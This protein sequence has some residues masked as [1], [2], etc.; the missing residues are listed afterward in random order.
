VGGLLE[1]PPFL[2][3]LENWLLLGTA[4]APKELL[5]PLAVFLLKGLPV[6]LLKGELEVLLVLPHEI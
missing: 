6:L 5:A 1:K 2:L 3:L 4:K